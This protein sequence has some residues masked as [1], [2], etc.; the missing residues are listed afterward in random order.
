[1]IPPIGHLSSKLLHPIASAFRVQNLSCGAP[2]KTLW[3]KVQIGGLCT[4]LYPSGQGATWRIYGDFHLT[5]TTQVVPCFTL[6][7]KRF[8]RKH[9]YMFKINAKVFY[10]YTHIKTY[11]TSP[12]SYNLIWKKKLT[13]KHPFFLEKKKNTQTHVCNETNHEYPKAHRGHWT[14][15][16]WK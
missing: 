9:T 4:T 3:Y 13:R 10:V 5:W 1:M 12:R 6:G 8:V 15:R 16:P 2:R 11:L 7:S 14:A